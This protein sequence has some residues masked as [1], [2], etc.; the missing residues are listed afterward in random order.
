[1]DVVSILLNKSDDLDSQELYLKSEGSNNLPAIQHRL[2]ELRELFESGEID[3]VWYIR[4]N[5][6]LP[7]EVKFTVLNKIKQLLQ[8]FTLS[9]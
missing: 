8:P 3:A 7:T 6:A 2:I 5:Q 9:N 1:V 4:L